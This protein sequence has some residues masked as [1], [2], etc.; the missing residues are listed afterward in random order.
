VGLLLERWAQV[1]DGHG[2]VILLSGD[3]G[4]GK[5]RLVQMLK[6]HIAPEPHVR[7]ECRSAEYYQNTAL[8][9]LTD[10]F[11]RLLR[12]HA[13]D[14]PDEKFGKLE[15]TLS[16]Y[17]LPL[18]ETVPLFTPLLSLPIPEDRYPL[19]NVSPQRQRQKTLETIIAILLELAER[20]PVLFILEDLHWTD[21]TTLELLNLLIDQTPTASMLVMLTCRPYFQPAWHHRSYLTEITVNRLSREQIER[22]AQHIAG[23]KSLPSAVLQQLVERT[24]GVPL[25]V[26]E[27]TKAVLESGH[28]QESDGQY[29]LRGSLT[30][31]AIPA[32]LQDSLMARLDRLMTAKVIAQLG[33]VIGRQFSYDLLQAVSQLDAMTLQRELGR[34]V[35][36]ELVYQR[37]VPPQSTYMFKHALIQDAAYQSLLKSTRQQYHQRIAQVLESQFPETTE[38]Q[39]ELVAQHCMEAGLTNQSATYW[40]KAAQRA[41]QRSAHVEAISHLHQ[42]LELL[43][44]LPETPGRTQQEVPLHIALGVSLAAIKSYAAPEVQQTYT[45]ARQLCQ[46]LD[47]PPQLFSVLCGLLH[48]HNVRA[49]YQTAHALGE[50]ILTLA[51]QVQDAAMLLAAHRALG[52]TLFWL[53]VVASAHTHA[54]QGIALYD[55]TQH[56]ASAFLYGDDWGVA[57]H[58]I[59]AWALW[60]LGY[61]EQGLVQ[62]HEAVTLAQQSAHP[63]SLGIALSAATIFHHY[64]HEVRCTQERAE[65]VMHL[66][67]AQGF[68]YWMAIGAILHG[69]TLAHQGEAKE[70]M[71]QITQG[72]TAY[73][74][75]GAELLRPYW[76]TLLAEAHGIMGQP[77]AGL[78]VLA[79]A[80]THVDTTGERW[81]EPE[82]YRLKGALLLQQSLDNQAEAEDCFHQAITIAQSQQAKSWELRAAMS[83][84]RFWQQQGKRQEAL[85]LLAPVYHWF[86]EG[87]DT[88][89]LQDAKALLHELEA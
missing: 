28:L 20:Q 53:G 41:V 50:Q 19:L 9:P 59:A 30:S 79:E 66:A 11:Q 55:P 5:S 4:I 47:D 38:T 3:A 89:D 33:A 71:A 54:A 18:E 67:K 24:D 70:G 16:Q 61:P 86:T 29:A 72:L 27:M 42:G 10:L 76:L 14:T 45:R 64:R 49:E 1:K 82:L 35:E 75:T 46:H 21:P 2:Q 77:E 52:Q 23:G 22:I 83:L 25:F 56:R 31:L 34:L 36:A 78:T 69:W 73:R 63:F 48:Y 88:A 74:A 7:W 37:G 60:L 15:R 6:E 58:S 12:F 85:D 81:C 26:E 17:R 39:P 68:P 80:L 87:F 57:C 51:Q 13:E 84:A 43:Q 65:A 62:S 32:T 8:F 40:Y 44:T